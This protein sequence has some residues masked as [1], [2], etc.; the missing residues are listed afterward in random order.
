[1]TELRLHQAL[2]SRP[3]VEQARGLYAD[4]AAVDLG[5]DGEHWVLRVSSDDPARER[6]VSGELANSALGITVEGRGQS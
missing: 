2:Y 6:A 3:A 4:Y 1:M 5:E